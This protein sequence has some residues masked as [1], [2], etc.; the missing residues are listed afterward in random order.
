MELKQ[1]CHHNDSFETMSIAHAQSREHNCNWLEKYCPSQADIFQG[2][3][4][5]LSFLADVLEMG[6][7]F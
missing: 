7:Q 6:L 4:K 5:T 2:K 3:T 1:E